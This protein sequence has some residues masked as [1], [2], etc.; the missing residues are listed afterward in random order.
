MLLA[1]LPNRRCRHGRLRR[2]S[3]A[4]RP[5]SIAPLARGRGIA[6]LLARVAPDQHKRRPFQNECRPAIPQQVF[7][8]SKGYGVNPATLA[9]QLAANSQKRTAT[10][11]LHTIMG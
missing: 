6:T 9:R 5:D 3:R 1:N 10:K 11:R 4:T 8:T 2:L 7:S